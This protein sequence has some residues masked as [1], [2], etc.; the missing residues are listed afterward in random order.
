MFDTELTSIIAI[1]TYKKGNRIFS[2]FFLSLKTIP[3]VHF[4]F[5]FVPFQSHV[6]TSMSWTSNQDSLENNNAK[7]N[8][9][10]SEKNANRMVFRNKK[11]EEKIRS[12]FLYV[13]MATI[14]VGSMSNIDVQEQ[15]QE[16]VTLLVLWS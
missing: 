3:L 14:E 12:P 5:Q 1:V 9:E 15:E 10:Q 4:F 6:P 16:N 13:T 2:L 7:K 11:C 8:E